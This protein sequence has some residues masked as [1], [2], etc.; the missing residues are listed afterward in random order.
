MSE[1]ISQD[2]GLVVLLPGLSSSA[3]KKSEFGAFKRQ[4][5]Q[6]ERHFYVGRTRNG[7]ILA[8]DP[9]SFGVLSVVLLFDARTPHL[10]GG[11]KPVE[12]CVC[13]HVRL[14]VCWLVL[15]L[16][17]V[18]VSAQLRSH[19]TRN[20]HIRVAAHTYVITRTRAAI[21]LFHFSPDSRSRRRQGLFSCILIA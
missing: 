9:V 16:C 6:I 18:C 7:K 19:K 14:C 20:T 1:Y 3:F 15:T 17:S 10:S 5:A 8:I 12:V 13:V 11:G 21:Y 4:N 2:P